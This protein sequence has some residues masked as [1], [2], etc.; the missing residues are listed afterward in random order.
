MKKMVVGFI[1]DHIDKLVYLIEKKRPN[2]QA[3]KLNGIGGHVEKGETSFKAMTRECYEETGVEI[4]DWKHVC[5]I[6]GDNFHLDV[7]TKLLDCDVN[8]NTMTDEHVD[9]YYVDRLYYEN[10][11]SDVEFL[12]PLCRECLFSNNFFRSVCF[13]Y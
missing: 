8:L 10:T 2:W 1:F 3:G 5:V 7:F 12:V 4:L 6:K 13:K 11:V 9:C